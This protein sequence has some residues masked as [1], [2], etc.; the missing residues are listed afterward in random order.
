MHDTKNLN[1]FDL[2][3]A[4]GKKG[5]YSGNLYVNKVITPLFVGSYLLFFI[6]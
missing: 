6:F 4:L 3:S 2:A 5:I 1:L